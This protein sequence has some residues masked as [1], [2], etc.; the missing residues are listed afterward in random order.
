[1]KPTIDADDLLEED[2]EKV[3][4][5]QQKAIDAEVA[6]MDAGG[7]EEEAYAPFEVEEDE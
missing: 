3:L 1:V 5:E 4:S 6:G 2:Q 7:G